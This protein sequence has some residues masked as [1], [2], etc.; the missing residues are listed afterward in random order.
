MEEQRWPDGEP[1]HYTEVCVEATASGARIDATAC[2]ATP[3][4]AY[5][6]RRP[7]LSATSQRWRFF[8]TSQSAGTWQILQP[9]RSSRL[10]RADYLSAD[11]Q[12]TQLHDA[13]SERQHAKKR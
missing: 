3:T 2:R 12:Q 9:R 13:R 5:A 1:Q 4:P 11:P 8:F 7:E 10:A 6:V